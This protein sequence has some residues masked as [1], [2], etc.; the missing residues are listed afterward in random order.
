MR[1]TRKMTTSVLAAASICVVSAFPS[2]AACSTNLPALLSGQQIS[3][4]IP[5]C[6]NT[7]L[8][9]GLNCDISCISGAD[10]FGSG[11]VSQSDIEQLIQ[12]YCQTNNCNLPSFFS[13]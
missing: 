13:Y 3:S 9:G 2:M 12:E 11:S 5:G 1:N 8:F 7:D 6:Q 10:C 4:C